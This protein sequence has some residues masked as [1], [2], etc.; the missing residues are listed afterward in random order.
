MNQCPCGS[1]LE[2]ENCCAPLI[3]GTHPAE[4]AEQ[5]MRSRYSAFAESEIEYLINTTHP[6]HKEG[7]DEKSIRK[8][9]QNSTWHRL[10]II[11]T[12]K[13]GSDDNEGI[14][15]FIAH[16]SE[17]N[18]RRKHHEIASFKKEDGNWLYFDGETPQIQQVVR[19]EPKTG[20]NDPCPCGS[21]KKFKKCC[22]R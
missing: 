22:G 13:G 9:S 20:R 1:D 3:K 16:Y 18:S 14:V 21:G 12:E 15:E 2:Y 5:L 6:D 7:M 11:N 4:T 10:E 17:K 19:S 8:W